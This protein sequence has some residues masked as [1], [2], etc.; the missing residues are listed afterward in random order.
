[1]GLDILNIFRFTAVDITR[2]VEVVVVFGIGNFVKRHHAGVTRN[3]GLLAKGIDN[4]MN[5]L[6][7]QAVFVTVFDKAL[8]GIDHKDAFAAGGVFF[9]QHQNTGGNA[10]A[11]KQVG[12]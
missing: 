3:G 7:A 10:G 2:Q 12:R 11:I 1:M 4:F 5:V 9:I 8:A 6:L